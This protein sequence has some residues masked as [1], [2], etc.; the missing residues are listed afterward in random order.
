MLEIYLSPTLQCK[1]GRTIHKCSHNE[2]LLGGTGTMKQ[3]AR[4]LMTIALLAV[5]VLGKGEV[6]RG[7]NNAPWNVEPLDVQQVPENNLLG[8]SS[9]EEGFYWKYPNHYVA[10]E[11]QRWWV[12]DG[13]PEY[14]DVRAWRPQRYDGNHAQIYF[15]WG[16]SYTA[17]IYQQITVRPCTHYQ[18]T[19]YGRNH[20][21]L[22]VN[23]HAKIGLDPLGREYGLYMP[24]LPPDITWSP[25]QTFYYTWGQH[26]VIAESRGYTMTAITYVSPDNVYTTYDTFW[27]AGTLVELPPP[28]GKLADPPDWDTG[29]FITGVLSYTLSGK[30]IVEWETAE[31]ASTQI[32]YRVH[33][34]PPT[35]PTTPTDTLV[36][37][38][39][40]LP[41]VMNS[42]PPEL[43]TYSMY[44]PI[45]PSYLTHHQT[46]IQGLEEG[47]IVEFVILARHLED[48]DCRTLSSAPFK[49]TVVFKPPVPPR[50]LAG[51]NMEGRE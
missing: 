43:A 17:G 18:F 10:N 2:L 27:D 5:L 22:A 4:H 21:N 31:P 40:Y 11:W 32:W 29:E 3:Y 14:D 37:P 42:Y 50:D 33:T 9:M 12:G 51:D 13:I 26:S 1:C 41:I 38:A 35:S 36:L 45:D 19:M 16:K 6:G 25:E 34:P 30:L 46:A 15:R 7:M 49:T 48:D 23:H 47:Q 24:S 20:S 28:P 39:I 44:T 8:N